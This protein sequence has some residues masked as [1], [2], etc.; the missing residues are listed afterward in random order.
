MELMLPNDN[1]EFRKLRQELHELEEVGART[2][3]CRFALPPTLQARGQARPSS[4]ACTRPALSR[5]RTCHAHNGVCCTC[6]MCMAVEGLPE[7]G[8]LRRKRPAPIPNI[9]GRRPP[10]LR[11]NQDCD[12]FCDLYEKEAKARKQAQAGIKT[13]LG[14]S[15]QQPAEALGRVRQIAA[16]AGH[17]AIST[18]LQ[19]ML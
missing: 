5:P 6:C 10:L 13:A 3:A 11:P 4:S 19:Q 18:C 17:A 15:M 7:S 8:R 9:P 14:G 2:G 1:G 12:H 16:L